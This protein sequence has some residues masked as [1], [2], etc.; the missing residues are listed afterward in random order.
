MNTSALDPRSVPVPTRLVGRL[1]L[2]V[3]L[4]TAACGGI[5]DDPSLGTSVQAIETTITPSFSLDHGPRFFEAQVSAPDV[6]VAGAP[7]AVSL[8]FRNTGT[9]V[10]TVDDTWQV[11]GEHYTVSSVHF[12]IDRSAPAGFRVAEVTELSS[13]A[14]D[15]PLP[16][17][18]D[19]AWSSD[20]SLHLRCENPG[21][22][23]VFVSAELGYTELHT[24]VPTP[25]DAVSDVDPRDPLYAAFGT[26]FERTPRTVSFNT[27]VVID[28][29]GLLTEAE[30]P[31]PPLPPRLLRNLSQD[32]A[33][34]DPGATIERAVE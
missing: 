22:F 34:L 13:N 25:E 8:R 19:T 28:C 21:R 17:A 32:G 16:A 20:V 7:I 27:A 29:T 24:H 30:E 11:G 33:T 31:P 1:G 23:R 18:T 6:V 5:G 14:G 12:T 26:E 4:L 15:L 10:R 2:A 3:A 9:I